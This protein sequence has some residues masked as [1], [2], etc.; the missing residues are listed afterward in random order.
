MSKM[1]CLLR[2]AA[3]ALAALLALPGCMAD[4]PEGLGFG[5]DAQTTVVMDFD[6]EP[7]P[8]MPLPNDLATRAD[9][10][11]PTGR[12]LNAS[13][14]A[15]TQ[16]ESRTR[17][18]I[19][20]L[21]G[22]GSFQPITV[23]FTGRLSITN[24]RERHDDADYDLSDDVIYL[25]DVDPD[26][27]EFGTFHHMD[28]GNGNYPAVL[29]S[30]NRYG[31]HDPRAWTL[32]LLFEEADEDLNDNGVLDPGEDTNRNG[33]LDDG[34][35]LDDDGVLDPPE[36]T[37]AD[38]VLDSPN[39]LPGHRPTVDDWAG[40]ADALMTFY[41]A[42]TNTLVARPLKPLRERT[43]YA[44]VVTNR[45]LDA[46]G[47]PVGSP[48]P[49][50]NHNAHTAGLEPLPSILSSNGGLLGN[51][52]IDDVVFAW[53][54]T[55]QSTMTHW[56]AVRDG[57]YGHGI[58]AHLG[59]DFPARLDGIAAPWDTET[60]DRENPSIL[61]TEHWDA[62]FRLILGQ[63][64]ELDPTT[65]AYA[66]IVDSWRYV[67][68]QVFGTYTS[69][70]LFNRVDD[71]GEPLGLNDQSWPPD[72][73]RVAAETR[74]ETVHFWMT[75]P[76]REMS[77]RGNDEPVPVA[78]LAHGYLTNRLELLPYVGFFAKYGFA[79][80]AIDDV[81]HGLDLSAEEQ[82]LAGFLGESFGLGP[83]VEELASGRAFDQ[84]GDGEIDAGS[85]FWTGYGFHN[86]DNVRQSLLDHVQA[87][88][89]LRSFDGQRRWEFDLDGDG[90]NELAG[91]FDADG[92]VDL[93][94]D[95][96]YVSMGGSLGGL[97]SVLLGSVEPAITAVAPVSG[98]AGLFDVAQRSHNPGV[99]EAVL[100]RL[101]GP[102][103]VGTL[104]TEAN[105]LLV[106]T[107]LPKLQ[108]SATLPVGTVSDVMVGDTLV[109]ENL[110]NGERGCGYLSAGGTVRASVATDDGDPHLVSLYRGPALITGSTTCEVV[111]GLQ[112]YANIDE[113]EVELDYL[114][115]TFEA[116][117]T[118]EALGDG[119]G[120]QRVTPDLRRS[121]NLAQLMG[122]PADPAV[123]ARHLHD[124]PYTYPGTGE[125][126]GAHAMV[127]TTLGDM[128][129]P[130]STGVA[131]G[132]AAGYIDFLNPDPRYGVPPN[133]ALID[134]YVVE[135]VNVL[136]RYTNAAGQGIHLDV[137]NFSEGTDMWGEDQ[138][139]HD[140]PFHF[141][142]DTDVEGNPR[143]GITGA[144]FPL[145]VPDGMHGFPF[146]GDLTDQ[147][148]ENCRETCEE[149]DGCGCDELVP[150]DIGNFMFNTLG[151][152][153]RSG[154]Q[155]FSIDMCN[156]TNDCDDFPPLPP[157]RNDLE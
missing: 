71:D 122:E 96:E 94:G 92:V 58:Q 121:L 13:I 116:G 65:S 104:D 142:S 118:L 52:D 84:D 147:H 141:W 26:S 81:S 21:D 38:G 120:H 119:L 138:P 74:P 128:A 30:P 18:L 83:L 51:L 49:F 10:N 137:E 64:F 149:D 22:W 157:V 134:T 41:E 45:L 7:N 42:E 70:Q 102:L 37:D 62:L 5:N 109:V 34:E 144:I 39:Y 27:P 129:V 135:S 107:F 72:L 124:D 88:R 112:A 14:I 57:L 90:E 15:P 148:L 110:V 85:D 130:G 151:R 93:G 36:D 75:V 55:T 12:R 28:L 11:S 131:L 54:F 59:Q 139:R 136:N 105:T 76:R 68:F 69:P 100:M 60:V 77:N 115:E 126:T 103:Y 19:D 44:V 24:I 67:D 117:S 86:R 91:D 87:I 17:E 16:Y 143:G 114:G 146:P 48:Y 8:L 123:Y 140:E 79:T 46:D 111:D 32:S 145:P 66:A 50:I 99:P 3:L 4:S 156:S 82:E 25:V 152:Y 20:E 40:R 150:F 125:T 2:Q 35:D 97:M 43:T 133:Q 9:P 78:I 23:P 113:F 73:D 56:S 108:R 29:E 53:T 63:L 1:N 80:I 132:R 127:V 153:M 95:V 31:K 33:Q 101:M 89:I 155:E 98:G 47:A 6:H 154:A 106:E 61:Y